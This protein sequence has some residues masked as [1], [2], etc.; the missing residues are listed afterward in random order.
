MQP[1]H[2]T[3]EKP[4]GG[5]FG[6]MVRSTMGGGESAAAVPQRQTIEGEAVRLG[7]SSAPAGIAA[8]NRTRA[9]RVSGGGGCVRLG[10]FQRLP[11][12]LPSRSNLIVFAWAVFCPNEEQGGFVASHLPDI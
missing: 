9:G 8:G 11:C 2:Q 7:D 1:Q 4:H 12:G 3:K 10:A 5:G 6:R